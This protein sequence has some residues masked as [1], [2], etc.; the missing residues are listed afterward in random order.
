[1]NLNYKDID[2]AITFCLNFPHEGSVEWKDEIG[3]YEIVIEND[4]FDSRLSDDSFRE[5]FISMNIQSYL[6]HNNIHFRNSDESTDVLSIGSFETHNKAKYF[7]NSHNFRLITVPVPLTNDSFGTNRISILSGPSVE[8]DYPAKTIFDINLIDSIPFRINVLGVGEFISLFTS[9]IDFYSIRSPKIPDS[10][11]MFIGEIASRL[12]ST[13]EQGSKKFI[14]LLAS[15]LLFKILIMRISPDYQIGCGVD[16]IL[17]GYFEKVLKIP[18][19]KAVYIGMLISL[20]LFPEWEKYGFSFSNMENYGIRI[21]IIS[22]S[23][24][25]K[26]TAI[27][28][29]DII[30]N[31]CKMRPARLTKISPTNLTEIEMRELQNHIDKYRK[32]KLWDTLN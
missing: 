32:S 14:H 9:I 7:S 12:L 29:S 22:P 23:D 15:A 16:H 4:F 2:R 10:I 19:G 26:A 21:G 27:K 3:S 31:A 24:L 6:N 20:L 1:M 5:I 18:H 17:A 13:S 25:D 30:L 8:G 11:I 28:V